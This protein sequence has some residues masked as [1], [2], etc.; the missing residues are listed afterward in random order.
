MTYEEPFALVRR[1]E[2]RMLETVTGKNFTVGVYLDY[3]FFTPQTS[4]PIQRER[5]PP[6]R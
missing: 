5:Q 6:A 1:N 2:G 3:P 4:G